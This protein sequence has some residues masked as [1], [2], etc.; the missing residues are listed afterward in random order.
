[1]IVKN[2]LKTAVL[3]VAFCSVFGIS[4]SISMDNNAKIIEACKQ[5]LRDIFYP[6]P[7]YSTE[8]RDGLVDLRFTRCDADLINVEKQAEK[9]R[10]QAL[11]NITHVINIALYETLDITDLD[12]LKK[13]IKILEKIKH[14]RV[15]ST[16]SSN[17]VLNHSQEI[18]D[19]VYNIYIN[20]H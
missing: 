4:N 6:I 1:M 18:I 12:I 5:Q 11:S 19:A 10:N 2:F 14:A 20:T 15:N 17:A 3:G 7:E 9:L 13:N 8:G 16:E